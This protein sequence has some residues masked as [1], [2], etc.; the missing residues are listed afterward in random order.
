MFIMDYSLLLRRLGLAFLLF[1]LSRLGFYFYNFDYFKAASLGET[2]WA[3]VYGFR[4]DL[5][6]VL[7]ANLFFVIFSILP[8]RSRLYESFLKWVFV[9]SNTIYL[10]FIIGDYEFFSFNGKKL[11]YDLFFMAQDIQDQSF[12]LA[13]NYWP[14]SLL[15]AATAAA[16]WR[17]YPKTSTPLWNAKPLKL[18]KALPLSLLVFVVTAIGVRGGLQL[19]SISPKE[20]FIFKNY[21]LGNLAL[22]SAYSLVRSF[23]KEGLH[24]ATYFPSD[25]KA[26]NKIL[27]QRDFSLSSVGIPDQNLVIIII[28]SLSQ[29]YV[30]QGFAP[31]VSSLGERGVYFS[32]NFA[33][34]RRSME[35]LPSIM[36]GFPSVVGTPLYQTQ[37]QSNQ[38][39]ALPK[40][41]K[42]NGYHSAFF[43]GGKRGTMDF[44][45]YC[46]S[47]G[48]DEYHAMEDY[49]HARHFDGHWGIFDH[50][51]LNYVADELD[52]FKNPFFA[53]VF[54]LSSHQPYSVPSEF[55]GKFPKGEL[56]I[57]ESIG[58]AD[59]ALRS[60][61]EKVGKKPWFKDT[62]FI[63]TADHTQKLASDRYNSAL[64]RYRV[65]LI[66]YHPGTSLKKPSP[67][68]ITQHVDILPSALDFLNIDY[69]QKLYYGASVFNEDKGRMINHNSGGH[70][71]LKENKMVVFN[72]TRASYYEVAEDLLTQTPSQTPQ[73]ELLEELKAYIQYTSN[74]LRGN[75]IYRLEE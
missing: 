11:T 69:P 2:I 32:R 24:K 31:F 48:F 54:T 21:E 28:E 26:L 22:N 6:T 37:Y 61:F 38:F 17:F 15:I 19:R 14:L 33:N 53:G 12:Q 35:A 64:G 13:L 70:M 43:H 10:G 30:D 3:Y 59:F 47:I 73:E 23:G 60:F 27:G 29:E 56:P 46:F 5:A 4:F 63:I 39:H 57:H 49:P 34:G 67:Q 44:D 65:P 41:L 18:Y 16:L 40:I 62:L 66:F 72:G 42:D 25:R 52:R 75:N 71:L 7:I 58:Y 20:A 8:Y 68:R 55:S 50:H 36:T 45:A 1:S 74:G 51:Y 9:I